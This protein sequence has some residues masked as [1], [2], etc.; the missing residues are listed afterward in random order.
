MLAVSIKMSG[1]RCLCIGGGA[2]AERR[3]ISLLNEKAHIEVMSPCVTPQIEKWAQEGYLIWQAQAYVTGCLHDVDFVFISTNSKKVNQAAAAEARSIGALVN[4][5]DDHKDCDF[6]IPSVLT[7]GD[8]RMTISTGMISPRVNK[9]IR[10]DLT[11]RYALLAEVLP[12]LQKVRQQLKD[13]LPTPKEREN[14]WQ[15]QLGN[16]ELQLILDGQ[17]SKVEEKLNHAISGI[18]IKS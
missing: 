11:H 18:R 2:V 13:L 16:Q 3:I 6:T 7:L 12:C 14:F 15:T 1:K 10:Q 4:R 5:A 9:L 8:L 17:W